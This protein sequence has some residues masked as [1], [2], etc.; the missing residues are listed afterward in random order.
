MRRAVPISL[1][2]LLFSG[3][4]ATQRD[5]LDLNQ[6]ADE[7][8][9][10]VSELKK[11][12]SSMQANQAD[13]SVKLDEVRGD[14]TSFTETLKDS[15]E[16]M[17]QLS[18]KIDDLK[19]VMGQKVT[20]LGESLNKQ[21]EAILQAQ[22]AAEEAAQKAAEAK[23]AAGGRPDRALYRTAE[24]LYAKEQW[25]KAARQYATLLDRYPKSP[26]TPSAR[27]KYALCLIKLNTRLPEAKRYLQSIGEDFPKSP[28]AAE[29]AKQLRR[30]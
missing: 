3:C 24:S 16:R 9:D 8:K 20:A 5:V 15:G 2:L 18:G 26:L 30:L 7:I 13:L 14:L 10:Q 19:A 4:I 1:S 27:L 29:A 25:E 12:L 23:E 6:Q 11:T 21:Q 28:E 17:S 22:K